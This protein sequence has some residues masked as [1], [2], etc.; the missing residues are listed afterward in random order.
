MQR[1]CLSAP[2]EFARH[3]I[4]QLDLRVHLPR[5]ECKFHVDRAPRVR[6]R[7]LHMLQRS[8]L[9]LD[10][11]RRESRFAWSN[12]GHNPQQIVVRMGAPRVRVRPRR[13][14]LLGPRRQTQRNHRA[15]R[16]EQVQI[17]IAHA[18]VLER[19]SQIEAEVVRC[20]GHGRDRLVGVKSRVARRQNPRQQFL[21]LLAR[22][23]VQPSRKNVRVLTNVFLR[24]RVREQRILLVP[25]KFYNAVDRALGRLAV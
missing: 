8:E 6:L 24:R 2:H 13:L 12:A 21:L 22:R 9:R 18:G 14:G 19:S 3:S 5:G 17:S 1:K 15:P 10:D 4:R 16:P 20:R 23:D 7:R 25:A 11:D